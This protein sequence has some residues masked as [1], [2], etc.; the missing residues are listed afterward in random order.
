MD[1]QRCEPTRAWDAF[2]RRRPPHTRLDKGPTGREVHHLARA[3]A[4]HG[5]YAGL[6]EECEMS[7]RTQAPIGH[8][9]VPWVSGRVD[10]LH[11]SEI[12][13]EKG[14]D[15]RLQE[16]TVAGMKQ[17]QEP[18]DRKAE[19]ASLLRRLAKGVL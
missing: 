17:P 5:V 18:R 12:V 11:L 15:H 6:A 7:I 8:E 13:G 9:H 16:H 10:R 4:P 2:D 19:P 1:T 14:R 3:D